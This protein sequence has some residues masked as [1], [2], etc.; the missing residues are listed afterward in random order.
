M[1]IDDNS[2][3]NPPEDGSD[4]IDMSQYI[5]GAS[6]NPPESQDELY[7]TPPIDTPPVESSTSPYAYRPKVDITP[8]T[9][10]INSI[11]EEAAKVLIAQEELVELIL[12]SI[13]SGGHILLE[14]VPGIAKTLSSKVIAR[15]LDTEFTRIQFTPDLMPSDIIGTSIFDLKSSE[16]SYIKGP[17]FSNV[18][19]IDEINR[20]PAKT[21]SALF[22]V[23]EEKQITFEGT[24]YPMEYPFFVMATQNPIEQEGTYRLP[25]A[26]LDRFLMRI[27]LDYPSLKDEIK[28]LQRYKNDNQKSLTE[29]ISKVLSTD[30]LKE[31]QGLT[32]EIF[33]SDQ[34][35]TYAAQIVNETR[36]HAKIY[37]G[38]SPRASLAIISTSKVAAIMAGRDFVTPD[39][40]KYM[41]PHILNHRILLTPEAEMEGLNEEHV[42]KEIL[43]TIEVPR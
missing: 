20:A 19:L 37:L 12:V 34:M 5:K 23:M 9:H 35:L 26:Q 14:G 8:F 3:V 16:F 31:L 40:I 42:I 18:I 17:I 27:K 6:P 28:I 25:E 39:D 22:E 7:S 30:D 11:Q 1:N 33:V 41:V 43:D 38:G 15:T 36:N 13:I 24:T 2:N 4:K 10:K 29:Q 32:K 21:Q